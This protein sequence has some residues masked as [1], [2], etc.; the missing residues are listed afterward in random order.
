MQVRTGFGNDWNARIPFG[1]K[2]VEFD[3]CHDLSVLDARTRLAVLAIAE[4]RGD[5][6][7]D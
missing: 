4:P 5:R 2:L 3:V 1:G 7:G 6:F